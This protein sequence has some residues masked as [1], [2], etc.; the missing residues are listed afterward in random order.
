MMLLRFNLLA[1]SLFLISS[2]GSA[3]GGKH[4]AT[5][6]GSYNKGMATFTVAKGGLMY[7]VSIGGQKFTYTPKK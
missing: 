4:D 6:A 1:V 7:E 2:S 3:S 5:T